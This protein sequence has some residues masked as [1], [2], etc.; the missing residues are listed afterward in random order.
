MDPLPDLTAALAALGHAGT[1]LQAVRRVRSHPGCLP[2]TC[3][4]DG[5]EAGGARKPLMPGRVPIIRD[6]IAR[7]RLGRTCTTRQPLG[8]YSSEYDGWE[9]GKV[10]RPQG[11]GWEPVSEKGNIIEEGRC[12]TSPRAPVVLYLLP[13]TSP[14]CRRYFIGRSCGDVV[15]RVLTRRKHRVIRAPHHVVHTWCM[16]CTANLEKET[17]KGRP[18]LATLPAFLNCKAVTS[19]GNSA[20]RV[21][22]HRREPASS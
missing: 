20:T 11:S 12:T 13:A 1:W 2:R 7:A 10:R 21:S 5:R 18:F 17:K 19:C 6:G 16:W 3:R 9:E 14:H 4:I 8:R 15:Q 22:H